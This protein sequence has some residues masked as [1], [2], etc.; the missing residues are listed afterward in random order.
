MTLKAD[1]YQ[2]TTTLA[3]LTVPAGQLWQI[4]SLIAAGL[5]QDFSLLEVRVNQAADS[6]GVGSSADE[7]V[8]LDNAPVPYGY[9]YQIMAGM[10]VLEAGDELRFKA[11]GLNRVSIYVS[12]DE[13]SSD[14]EIKRQI[15]TVPASEGDV[16]TVPAG[17]T[18]QVLGFQATGLHTPQALLTV[19]RRDS[20][21]NDITLLHEAAIYDA[22]V[23][24]VAP[25][26]LVFEAGDIIRASAGG[27]DRVNLMISYE[28][29]T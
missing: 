2:P 24:P 25:G 23:H 20:A 16:F 11:D 15:K 22:A 8:I 12:Y 3:G 21:G 28:E 10:Q 17:R 6:T 14:L 7:K 26:A 18:W 29:L 1:S 13:Q 5:H 9:S 19:K 27:A 4:R